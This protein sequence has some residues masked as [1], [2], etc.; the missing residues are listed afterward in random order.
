MISKRLAHVTSALP[1]QE[2]AIC[3]MT[4]NAAACASGALLANIMDNPQSACSAGHNIL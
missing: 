3:Q 4:G 2:E 1:E